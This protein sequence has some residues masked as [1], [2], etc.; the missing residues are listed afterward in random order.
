MKATKPQE[1][2]KTHFMHAGVVRAS[3]ES[4]SNPRPERP[5][6]PVTTTPVRVTAE[7]RHRMI[8]L[9]AHYQAARRCVTPESNLRDWLDAE[10]EVKRTRVH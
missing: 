5:K 9:A 3:P 6:D 7:E 10:A 4:K 1:R 2:K 8:E